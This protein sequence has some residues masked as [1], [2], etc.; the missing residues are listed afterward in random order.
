MRDEAMTM[1]VDDA[2]W[3]H[4]GATLSAY[5][6][7]ARGPTFL[8]DARSGPAPTAPAAPFFVWPYIWRSPE[9]AL[10]HA[11]KAWAERTR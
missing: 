10:L 4:Q 7:K 2:D 8:T 3:D 9:A 1:R 5:A 11:G 6:L